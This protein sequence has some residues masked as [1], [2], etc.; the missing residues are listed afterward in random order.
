MRSPVET[1]KKFTQTLPVKIFH[2]ISLISLFLMI[3]SG[4]QIYNANPVFG[5]RSGIHIPPILGLGGWL[6]GGRHWHF[7]MMWIFMLNLL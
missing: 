3:T 6:A 7:A 1:S 4:L 2:W 5:G